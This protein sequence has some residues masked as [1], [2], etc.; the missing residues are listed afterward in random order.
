[1]GMTEAQAARS[2]GF[3]GSTEQKYRREGMSAIVADHAAVKAGFS[4]FEVWPEWGVDA[5]EEALERRRKAARESGRRRY[6]ESAEV[7]E[8]RKEAAKAWR[9]ASPRALAHQPSRQPEARR[10]QS[11][12]YYQRN[13]EAIRAKARERYAAR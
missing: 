1:M 3:S 10:E 12:S 2:L 13:A 8:K 7:R 9:Q 6:R 11:R 5:H 4:P